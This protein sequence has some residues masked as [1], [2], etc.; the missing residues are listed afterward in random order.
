MWKQ[1]PQD[2][3]PF[4]GVSLIMWTYLSQVFN[5]CTST[6]VTHGNLYPHCSQRTRA[7]DLCIAAPCSLTVTA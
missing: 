3:M 1:P 5:E 6:F 2:I 4:F 7:T